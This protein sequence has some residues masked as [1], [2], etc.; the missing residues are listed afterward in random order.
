MPNYVEASQRSGLKD[1]L[2]CAPNKEIKIT[3]IW[4]IKKEK[5]SAS[6][7]HIRWKLKPISTKRFQVK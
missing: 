1:I 5:L 7:H 2:T 6:A 4:D 3:P